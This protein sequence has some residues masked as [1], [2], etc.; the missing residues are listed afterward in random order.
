MFL[1]VTM[2]RN[3]QLIESAIWYHQQGL[4]GPDTYVV[5][6]DAVLGNGAIMQQVAEEHKIKLWS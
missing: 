6:L 2:K 4:I 5:D 3:P 1:D